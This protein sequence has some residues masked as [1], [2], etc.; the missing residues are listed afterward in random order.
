MVRNRVWGAWM[1]VNDALLRMRRRSREN[2][3]S[4][5]PRRVLVCVGGHLGD[6]VIATKALSHLSR[7]KPAVEIGVLSGSWNREILESLPLV[8]WFHNVD[9][10]KLN[11][12]PQSFPSKW[13]AYRRSRSRA[14]REIR[15]ANYDAAVDLYA[16]YPNFASTIAAARVPV[17]IGYGTGGS[18]PLYTRELK[19]Q[20]GQPISEDHR[21]IM[22]SLIPGLSWDS[23]GYALN[24]VPHAA[25]ERV[26]E[27]LRKL[28]LEPKG[29]AILHVGGGAA[30]KEWPLDHW[31]TVACEL[32]RGSVPV[33]LTGAGADDAAKA[34]SLETAVAGVKNLCDRLPWMEFRAV[35]AQAAIVLSVDTVAMHL[36]AAEGTPCVAVMTG[37]DAP[38]R[39]NPVAANMRVLTH[40]V[41]CAP[42]YRSRGCSEMLC[43]RGVDP[44]TL[45]DAAASFLPK[46]SR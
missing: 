4:A 8:R 36:A 32:L 44:S 29:Y 11:R 17:R 37:I 1:R 16:Y 41:S 31:V 2:A 40:P 15:D 35:I 21:A 6:A 45:L 14:V 25:T 7:T 34:R 20:A 3:Q 13:L 39:W 38:K 33:V 27:I 30:L 18:G 5:P 23:S 22:E 24:E 46:P 42:C 43:V 9:H 19:W 28:R 10:W 12:K 26:A